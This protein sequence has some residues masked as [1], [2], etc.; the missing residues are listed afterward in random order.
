M[1]FDQLV[2]QS[3]ALVPV[4]ALALVGLTA[5]NVAHAGLVILDGL[6]GLRQQALS[7]PPQG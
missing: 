2:E 5:A 1:L 3:L 6:I 7:A 4:D